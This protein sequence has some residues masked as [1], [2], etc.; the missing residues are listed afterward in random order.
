MQSCQECR[1]KK[2][3]GMD[4]DQSERLEQPMQNVHFWRGQIVGNDLVF[5]SSPLSIQPCD[6]HENYRLNLSCTVLQRMQQLGALRNT[7]YS[8]AQRQSEKLCSE[9]HWQLDMTKPQRTAN[10]SNG[11]GRQQGCRTTPLGALALPPSTPTVPFGW[12]QLQSGLL[13][14][15]LMSCSELFFFFCTAIVDEWQGSAERSL[16]L[17]P[18]CCQDSP[19][20]TSHNS[21]APVAH[22]LKVRCQLIS[23]EGPPETLPGYIERWPTCGTCCNSTAPIIQ[24]DKLN[25]PGGVRG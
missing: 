2:E 3:E 25:L 21:A 20:Q 14:K 8:T 5:S 24:I 6:T 7:F 15:M 17:E 22:S 10:K 16:S 9:Q 23:A 12:H 18:H 1:W 4:L 13:G 11:G 19:G